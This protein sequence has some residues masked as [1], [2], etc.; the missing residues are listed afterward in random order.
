MMAAL[1]RGIL[2]K[3]RGGARTKGERAAEMAAGCL[4]HDGEGG[5]GAEGGDI[6]EGGVEEVEP[7][8]RDVKA[9]AAREQGDTQRCATCVGPGGDV[10]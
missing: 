3:A 9:C 2:R 8:V 6:G 7:V 1:P 4:Q 5:V 10:A